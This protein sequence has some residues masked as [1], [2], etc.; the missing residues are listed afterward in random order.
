MII[1]KNKCIACQVCQDYCPAEAIQY[2]SQTESMSVIQEKCFECG[3]CLNV[4]FCPSDAFIE[5]FDVR[6]YP[7]VVSSLFSNPNTIH[8]C[9]KVPGRG[10]EESKTNDVRGRIKHGEVGIL[11]EF[12]RPGAGCTFKD[13]SQMTT[14][15]KKMGAHFEKNNPLYALMDCESG[16]F[17]KELL[18]QR[19]LSTIIELKIQKDELE[20]LI[21]TIKD[22]SNNIDTVFSLSIICRFESE[23]SLPVLKEL[24]RIGIQARPNAK[25]NLGMGKPLIEK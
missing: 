10:T 12:G 14:Q 9:S 8:K 16:S 11:I 2:D 6:E 20:N 13:I 24:Q 21:H 7:K 15:L 5:P 25:I 19:I 18:G 1:D 3:L 4:D 23:N 22:V 17:P